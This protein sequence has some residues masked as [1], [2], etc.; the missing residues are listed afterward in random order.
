M[1]PVATTGT[2]VWYVLLLLAEEYGNVVPDI[3][4]QCEGHSSNA[5]DLD[6]QQARLSRQAE[7]GSYIDS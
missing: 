3:A 6:E 5:V 2:M 4:G 1:A 7:S